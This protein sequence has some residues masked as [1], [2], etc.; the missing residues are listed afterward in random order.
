VEVFNPPGSDID[1]FIEPILVL[2]GKRTEIE[3]EQ[4]P[5]YFWPVTG[6][7]QMRGEI[8]IY[9]AG[10]II[11]SPYKSVHRFTQGLCRR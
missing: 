5:T 6:K 2:A 9:S 3:Q 7:W 8:Y 11:Q 4:L 1:S 10:K